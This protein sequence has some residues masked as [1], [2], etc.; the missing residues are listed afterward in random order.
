MRADPIGLEGGIDPYLYVFN[1]PI[2]FT[3]PSGLSMLFPII[4]LMGTRTDDCKL[5]EWKV[6]EG[7]CSHG[8][9]GCYVTV[10]WRIKGIRGGNLIRVEERTVNCNCKEP[11]CDS[12]WWEPLVPILPFLPLITPWPDPY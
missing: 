7:R 1:N 6:C 12:K 8:V 10:R 3:D 9:D 11:P 2:D 5:S 4:Y